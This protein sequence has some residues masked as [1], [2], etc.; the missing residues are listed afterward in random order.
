MNKLIEALEAAYGFSRECGL[1][2]EQEKILGDHI[3]KLKS[4]DFN[5]VDIALIDAYGSIDNHSYR[6]YRPEELNQ[7]LSTLS[8]IRNIFEE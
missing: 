7:I 3:Q 2:E 1:T 4:L 6:S 5:E 8:Q